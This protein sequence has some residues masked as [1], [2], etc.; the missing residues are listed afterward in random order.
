M[1]KQ[2]NNKFA[3]LMSQSDND[4]WQ[5]MTTNNEINSK[6]NKHADRKPKVNNKL[7]KKSPKKI[8][9]F[10]FFDNFLNETKNQLNIS[11]FMIVNSDEEYMEALTFIYGK[12]KCF[13]NDWWALNEAMGLLYDKKLMALGLKPIY[14]DTLREP[15]VVNLQKEINSMPVI[16]FISPI[17]LVREWQNKPKQWNLEI[18]A[19][20]KNPI[21][22]WQVIE[23]LECHNN[24]DL[25]FSQSLPGK[26]HDSENIFN[27]L[28]I[29][30]KRNDNHNYQQQNIKSIVSEYD[31]NHSLWS[32]IKVNDSFSVK[33][34]IQVPFIRINKHVVNCVDIS[35]KDTKTNYTHGIQCMD[36]KFKSGYIPRLVMEF[37][38][39][40]LPNEITAVV[41][42]KTITVNG[43][44]YFKGYR[45][46]T[47]TDTT[48][49]SCLIKCKEYITNN[50]I[51][52]HSNESCDYSKCVVRV[53]IPR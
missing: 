44:I 19:V 29:N 40:I 12:Y 35:L 28:L 2:N 36:P 24:T 16:P 9:C 21:E 7:V 33:S 34:D 47:L 50:F 13:N 3:I 14:S 31:T 23:Q 43:S 51:T 26:E 27:K 6:K 49:K 48:D 42:N 8:N 20:M 18:V 11:D 5:F 4:C 32:F 45:V 10:E 46:M 53:N 52:N 15:I 25:Q 1:L 41:F 17:A 22:F 38:C 30:N 39:G 37:V